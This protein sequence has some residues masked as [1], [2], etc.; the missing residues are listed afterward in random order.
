MPKHTCDCGARYSFPDS[1]V[2]KRAKCQKCGQV[3]TLG[4]D[5]EGPITVAPEFGLADEAAAAVERRRVDETSRHESEPV[6]GVPPRVVIERA[7]EEEPRSSSSTGYFTNLLSTV[8][9]VRKPQNVI[10]FLF[11]WGMLSF[12]AI[13]LSAAGC[14]G[15]IGSIIIIGWYCAYRFSV[16]EDAAAGEGDLPGF[17]PEG[18]LYEGILLPLVKWIASWLV[19][20]IPAF[21][22]L[23]VVGV[24]GAGLAIFDELRVLMTDGLG[25]MVQG[26]AAGGA[27]AAV[28]LALLGMFIWPLLV[29]CVA[30]GGFATVSRVDLMV[31]TIVKTFP[32]YLLTVAIV[33]G[34]SFIL[35]MIEFAPGGLL[36]TALIVGI[37]LYLEIVALRAIG[38]YYHH[39]KD[40]FAWSWG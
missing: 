29:L 11:L 33:F 25:G 38:L 8:L 40:R 15:L 2:G 3:L 36:G 6:P 39:F 24:T 23:F 9:F 30:L 31:V 4:E 37:E 5:N 18:G 16:I 20:L 27:I 17:N 1:A 19:V 13:L 14:L 21:V 12:Q 26:L 35:P 34:T 28:A 22:V 7:S 32:V 10:M